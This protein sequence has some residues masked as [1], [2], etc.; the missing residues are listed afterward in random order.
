ML[1]FSILVEQKIKQKSLLF[2]VSGTNL[3]KYKPKIH[4]TQRQ[5]CS[6]RLSVSLWR[7]VASF[8]ICFITIWRK[9]KKEE[10]IKSL[11]RLW[12]Y[13]VKMVVVVVRRKVGGGENKSE[14]RKTA[15]DFSTMYT[16]WRSEANRIHDS[17][18]KCNVCREKVHK[19]PEGG[20]DGREWS[21]G[22]RVETQ[23]ER[24]QI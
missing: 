10:K 6:W 24:A 19:D 16:F 3:F 2:F 7:R 18:S 14:V 12:V 11:L 22:E 5:H 9:R 1:A 4:K 15:C 21:M 13:E 20:G 8:S 17:H 23:F